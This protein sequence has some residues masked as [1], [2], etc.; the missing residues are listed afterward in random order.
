MFVY[1]QHKPRRTYRVS[2]WSIKVVETKVEANP[3]SVERYRSNDFQSVKGNAMSLEAFAHRI[4]MK[5][6]GS[7]E[8]R[9]VS[10]QFRL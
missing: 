3:N 10:S 1:E 4:T 9:G 8:I 2:L 6:L 5:L 7:A